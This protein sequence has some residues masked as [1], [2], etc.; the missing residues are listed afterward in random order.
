MFPADSPTKGQSW[1][2]AHMGVPG[3]TPQVLAGLSPVSL[4]RLGAGTVPGSAVPVGPR[5][6]AEIGREELNESHG[7]NE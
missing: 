6:V 5:R 7:T 2:W 3:A 1:S 4:E